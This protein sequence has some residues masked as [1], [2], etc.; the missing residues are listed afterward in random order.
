MY[1]EMD[2]LLGK[3]MKFVDEK[4]ALLVISDHGFKAFKRGVD[5]NAWLKR[6]GYLS[7]KNG[8]S[9]AEYLRQVDWSKTKAYALGLGGMFINLKGRERQ[10]VVEVSDVVALKEEIKSKLLTLTDEI[11]DRRVVN[12]IFDMEEDFNGPYRKEGPDLIVGF[13][14]GFRVSW[15]CARGK[16]TD[17]V[18]EDNERSWSGDHCIDPDLV[19]GVFFSNIRISENDPNI[20]DIAPTVLKAFGIDPPNYMIGKNLFRDLSMPG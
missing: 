16:V 5:L 1:R 20:V 14:E 17:R 2:K 12:R 18:I 11:D 4:T 9:E 15:D 10:G 8:D 6:N 3:T 13:A 19:P 7:L